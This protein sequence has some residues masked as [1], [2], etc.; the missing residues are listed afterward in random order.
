VLNKSAIPPQKNLF[1]HILH[2]KYFTEFEGDLFENLFIL[3]KSRS[4]ENIILL[5]SDPKRL[6]AAHMAGFRVIPVPSKEMLD[7]FELNIV[8]NYIHRLRSTDNM[9]YAL[10]QNFT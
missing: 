1:S 9:T 6:R 3:A 10:G 5:S 7:D 4:I 2:K 8:E